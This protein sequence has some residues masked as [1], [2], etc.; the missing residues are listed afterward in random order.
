[1]SWRKAAVVVPTFVV[2]ASFGGLAFAAGGDLDVTFSGDGLV[3]TNFTNGADETLGVSLQTDGKIVVAG[4]AAM[5]GGSFAL[6]R[7]K[8]DGSLDSSFSGDGK[9]TT[10]FTTGLDA[11]RDLG[12]QADGKIVAAGTASGQGGRF[13]VARFTTDGSLDTSFSGDGK[14]TTDFTSGND[15]SRDMA[16]QPNGRIVAVGVASAGKSGRWAVGRYNSNGSLDT[17]FS[18][19]G[20]LTL[21]LP[22][23]DDRAYGV[24]IQADGK[25]V[26]GG[27]VSRDGGSFALVRLNS[28]GS[29][30]PTFDGDGKVFTNLTTG[31]D[32]AGDVTIQPDGKILA[33]GQIGGS[34][35]KFA[36]LRY[37]SDGTLDAAFDGD[38]MQ[39]TDF[40][41]G[42]DVARDVGIQADGRLVTVGSADRN[43][44]ALFA[45]ARY[46]ADGTIDASFGTGGKLTTDFSSG[47]D[48]AR[49][50]A[51]QADGRIVAAGVA[52][53]GR[54]ATFAVARYVAS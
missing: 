9:L 33:P 4:S 25:V 24:A 11:A 15:D 23:G 41:D 51:I 26:V 6:A 49:D 39:T 31:D 5:S 21:D 50:V 46:N 17:S 7:Y 47:V 22:S 30:D 27:R 48:R 45:L 44:S 8:T 35:P 14:A 52:D 19:D 40:T 29:L 28:N 53:L 10:N 43:G 36:L 16:I 38:G 2:V 3:T 12:I 37:N 13:A 20:K 54:N 18:G 1:M 42:L 32:Y 34:N